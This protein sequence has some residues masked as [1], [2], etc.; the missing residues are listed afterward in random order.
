MPS[1]GRKTASLIWPEVLNRH[2][3]K[4]LHSEMPQVALTGMWTVWETLRMNPARSSDALGVSLK[5]WVLPLQ[6]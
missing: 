6:Q 5:V 4:Q 1:K 3:L 2:L